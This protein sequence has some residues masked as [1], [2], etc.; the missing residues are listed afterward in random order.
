MRRVLILLL[1]IAAG[2]GL[3]LWMSSAPGI[4]GSP[5]SPAA[6]VQEPRE[7][8]PIETPQRQ[9][10]Q[11][12]FKREPLVMPPATVAD[13]VTDRLSAPSLEQIERY[14]ALHILP[15]NPVVGQDCSG[16]SGCE[17]LRRDPPHPYFAASE[18][19]LDEIRY[20]DPVAALVLARRATDEGSR[21][22]NYLAA[23]AL[24]GKPGP[25]LEL[26]YGHYEADDGDDPAHAQRRAV[27]EAVAL[28][29]GDE[30]A[31]PETWQPGLTADAAGLGTDASAAR[32]VQAFLASIEE[33][34]ALAGLPPLLPSDDG[35]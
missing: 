19:S 20:S 34:R 22:Q 27:L 14:N 32:G 30:R 5:E 10:L 15:W 25:L 18:A 13:M 6:I 29:L 9:D 7:S 3:A 26:A 16:A 2:V 8:A 31:D 11:S 35:W 1:A 12:T 23:V 33:L 28:T 24:S 17:V 4:K 21:L